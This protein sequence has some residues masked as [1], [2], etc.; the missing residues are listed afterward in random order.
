M[1]TSNDADTAQEA[2][3]NEAGG[4]AWTLLQDRLDEQLAPV[5]RVLM[6]AAALAGGERVL[7]VGCGCG[8]TTL[9]AADAVGSAGHAVGVDVSSPMLGRARERGEGRAN[10]TWR[11]ANAAVERHPEAPFDALISRFG[12]MFFGDPAAAFQNLAAQLRPGG[13]VVF[14]CWQALDRNEMMQLPLRAAGHLLELPPPPA[15]D[16]PG[17]GAFADPERVRGILERAGLRGIGFEAHDAPLTIGRTVEDALLVARHVGP[18]SRALAGAP[19]ET[20]ARA[21]DALRA[22][23]EARLASRGSLEVGAPFWIVRALRP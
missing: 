14:A 9:R 10:V 17:P 23:L 11:L 20:A 15:P 13:R 21:L 18:L 22:A 5:T 4:R 6:Q 12:V 19:P 16:Q 3:W 2:L 1:Q 7:D 8:D